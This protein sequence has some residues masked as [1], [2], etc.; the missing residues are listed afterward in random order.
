MWRSEWSI[1]SPRGKPDLFFGLPRSKLLMLHFR[2]T[3]A[4]T[5]ILTLGRRGG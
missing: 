4:K 1:S 5:I 3:V 2:A